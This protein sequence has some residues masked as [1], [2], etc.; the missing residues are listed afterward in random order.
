MTQILNHPVTI[1]KRLQKSFGKKHLIL[2]K[3]RQKIK[4]HF[5]NAKPRQKKTHIF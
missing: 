5:K 3:W 1:N 4:L 2:K